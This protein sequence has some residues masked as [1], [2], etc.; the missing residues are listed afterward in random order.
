MKVSI[1]AHDLSSN[2]SMR[3]HRLAAMAEWFAEVE[4]IG[5]VTSAGLWPALPRDP[6]VRTFPS[7][8]FPSFFDTLRQIAEAATGDVLVACGAELV[9]LGAAYLASGLVKRPVVLDVDRPVPR[10]GSQHDLSDPS[11]AAYASLMERATAGCDAL[12]ASSAAR[13]KQLGATFLAHGGI[14]VDP[15]RYRR[16]DARM[17]FNLPLTATVAVF[18]GVP[19]EGFDRIARAA[20]RC[21]VLL[22]APAQGRFPE[23]ASPPLIRMPLMRLNEVPWLLAASDVAVVHAGDGSLPMHLFDAMAMGVPIVATENPE[24]ADVLDGNAM[25]VPP[26]DEDALAEAVDAVLD[27]RRNAKAMAAAAR[28]RFLDLYTTERLSQI[29]ASLLAG[30]AKRAAKR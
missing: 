17:R 24:V 10:D 8:K 6:R 18:P 13:A 16:D 25:L 28:E 2:A 15:V 22:A 4:L 23:L 21:R 29:F 14:A 19:G 5:P 20:E 9:S 27:D 12:I 1:L 26:G 30:A 11:D 7:A 3:A